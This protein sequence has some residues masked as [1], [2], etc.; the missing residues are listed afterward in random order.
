MFMMQHGR[1]CP[2]LEARTKEIVSRPG[3][4]T[5]LAYAARFPHDEQPEMF[6]L[7]RKI[8]ARAAKRYVEC[9]MRPPTSETIAVRLL[10]WLDREFP[11]VARS[12]KCEALEL[13]L[14]AASQEST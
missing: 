8:G 9:V 2:E 14:A 4:L 5:V 12:L 6:E 7:F 10:A 3:G 13:A 1:L 11:P